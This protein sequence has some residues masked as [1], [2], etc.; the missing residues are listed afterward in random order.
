[1]KVIDNSASLNYDLKGDD[2]TFLPAA[3]FGFVKS[4]NILTITE[5]GAVPAGDTFKRMN[6]EVFDKNGNSKT[7]TIAAAAGN[8]AI[9]LD[10]AT[11]LDLNGDIN[12]KVTAVTS[13]GLAKDGW[14]YGLKPVADASESLSFEK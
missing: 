4:T 5:A 7:G 1:M 3:T 11:S 14:Y 10:A 6:V 13:N 2:R 12:I 9:D 8:V